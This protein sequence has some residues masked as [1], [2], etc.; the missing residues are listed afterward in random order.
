MQNSQ[1]FIFMYPAT[2]IADP[3]IAT[4]IFLSYFFKILFIYLRRGEHTR[5]G[6]S[7][8]PAVGFE[9][10]DPEIMTWAEGRHST[11]CATQTL[12]YY[13][14]RHPLPMC[15]W[16][17]KP[18]PHP[19]EWPWTTYNSLLWDNNWLRNGHVTRLRS[20]KSEEKSARAI[21]RFSSPQ[22]RA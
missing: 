1:N 11:D 18:L 14:L 20:I 5:R 15:S 10:Q 6:R 9:Y 13:F 16:E 7:K 19:T 12:S 22:K 4:P 3:S 2:Y 21:I 17:A 8:K